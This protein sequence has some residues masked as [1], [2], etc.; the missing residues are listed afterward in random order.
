MGLL[1][2]YNAAAADGSTGGG[3]GATSSAANNL[4]MNEI[5]LSMVVRLQLGQQSR[6]FF[7]SR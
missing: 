1:K 3:A 5:D 2:N 4:P 7:K 6:R